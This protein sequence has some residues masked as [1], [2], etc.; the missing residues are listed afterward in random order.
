MISSKAAL[1]NSTKIPLSDYICL[2]GINK[3][4]IKKQ[5]AFFHIPYVHRTE[6]DSKMAKEEEETPKTQMLN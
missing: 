1:F 5:P 2:I 4:I 6:N 3:K